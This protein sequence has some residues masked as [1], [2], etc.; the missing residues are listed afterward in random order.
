MSS[1]ILPRASQTAQGGWRLQWYGQGGATSR[2]GTW[3]A[4]ERFVQHFELDQVRD[5]ALASPADRCSCWVAIHSSGNCSVFFP[6]QTLSLPPY[7][8]HS[9]PPNL[10]FQ[11]FANSIS[12]SFIC[13]PAPTTKLRIFALALGLLCVQP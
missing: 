1:W 8:K 5:T 3:L 13:G 4:A 9:T 2:C 11:F 6:Y 10:G 12:L 7:L